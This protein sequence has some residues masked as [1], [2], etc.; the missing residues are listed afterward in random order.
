MSFGKLDYKAMTGR[1][2]DALAVNSFG[3]MLK[4]TK[5]RA[6]SEDFKQDSE[7]NG[8]EV[9]GKKEKES[10][11]VFDPV[12]TKTRLR[13]TPKLIP[14]WTR[15]IPEEDGPLILPKPKTGKRPRPSAS[16][17]P[18]NS[19]SPIRTS[20]PNS[21]LGIP[22]HDSDSDS[23]PIARKRRNPLYTPPTSHAPSTTPAVIHK[24]QVID[25]E[26]CDRDEYQRRASYPVRKAPEPKSEHT[27]PIMKAEPLSAEIISRTFLH[28]RADNMDRGP[29]RV[30]FTLCKTSDRLFTSLMSE[31][32]IRYELHDRVSDISATFTWNKQSI[33]IR[34]GRAEDWAFFCDS[35]RKAWE[36]ESHRF[37][38]GCNIDIMIHVDED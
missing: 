23:E 33:G 20:R 29:V 14:G 24:S 16:N 12:E 3:S 30:P 31:R 26:N 1:K 32:K 38:E 28:V 9:S 13:P 22:A 18:T 15:H 10:W 17:I 6:S 11:N 19:N 2:V 4:S 36:K 37:A 35:L 34:K 27:N 21:T 7:Q 25:L 8:N 5:R